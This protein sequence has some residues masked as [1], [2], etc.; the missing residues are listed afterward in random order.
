MVAQSTILKWDLLR[1]VS[2]ASLSGTYMAVGTPFTY[3]ARVLKVINASTMDV[4]VS[5]DGVN[6]YDYVVS[7]GAFI[8]DCGTNKGSSSN[9]LEIPEGTQI[10]CKGTAG[11]GSIYV[12]VLYGFT[13]NQTIPGV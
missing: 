5:I 3:P 7:G 4:T 13:P 9:V 12:V 10:Y 2:S 6:D 8:Y 1:S 11:T